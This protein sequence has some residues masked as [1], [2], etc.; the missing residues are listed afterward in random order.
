VTSK[1]VEDIRRGSEKA[2]ENDSV[3]ICEHVE[4][5]EEREE[6]MNT[7]IHVAIEDFNAMMTY[8]SEQVVMD[9]DDGE[10]L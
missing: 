6:N 1:V 2:Q 4:C 9:Q 7:W 5:R 3:H 10:D 8:D